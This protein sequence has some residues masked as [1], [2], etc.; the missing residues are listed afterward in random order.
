MKVALKIHQVIFFFFFLWSLCVVCGVLLPQP[1][2]ESWLVAV[3]YQVLNTEPPGNSNTLGIYQQ[4][5]F[6]KQLFT[7]GS[8]YVIVIWV[9]SLAHMHTHNPHSTFE[10]QNM[11]SLFTVPSAILLQMTW[12]ISASF[13]QDEHGQYGGT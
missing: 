2:M 1:R 6:T 7:K 5:Q 13:W 12:P 10:M 11:S 3:K 4:A 9:Q 8:Y